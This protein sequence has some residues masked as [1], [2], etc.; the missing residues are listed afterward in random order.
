MS[1][2]NIPGKSPPKR[3]LDHEK[4]LRQVEFKEQIARIIGWVLLVLSTSAP[5]Y[6]AYRITDSVAGKETT[7]S[8]Q[9]VAGFAFTITGAGFTAI[10]AWFKSRKQRSTI[11]RLRG[12]IAKLEARLGIN[13]TEGT[14]D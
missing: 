1:R 12:R 11:I 10:I 6:W 14:D 4:Y 3:L 5:M 13:P 7:I 9:I 8:V 2:S